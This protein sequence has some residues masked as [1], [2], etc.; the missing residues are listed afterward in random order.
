MANPVLIIVHG[1]GKHTKES[2]KK[3]F[4]DGSCWALNLYS[5]YAGKS[6]NDY[7]DIVPIS[8]NE[9]F[10]DHRDR[11]ANQASPLSERL[12][13]IAG[14]KGT[15][16]SKAIASLNNIDV[17]INNDEHF[18]THWLDVLLYRFTTLGEVA[19][20]R[21]GA[22]ISKAVGTVYGGAERVHVLGHSLGCAVVHDCLAKLYDKDYRLGDLDNLSTRMHKLGSVHLVANT[23][24]VLESFIKVNRSV[25]RPG[26]RGCTNYYREYRHSLDPITWAKPFNPTDNGNWISTSSMHY[27]LYKLLPTTSITN[28]HGNTHNIQH[29]LANPLVHQQLFERVFGI[30]FTAV[31]LEE[32]HQ[33]YI[34]NTLSGV[35]DNLQDSLEQLRELNLEN[36]QGLIKSAMVL[37]DFVERLG[38]QYE[39]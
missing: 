9:I 39:I 6:P 35:A 15:V 2:F 14:M 33:N 30:R 27:D 1:M 11:V 26:P 29:Y 8:Y 28:E 25:V 32:G 21:L 3:E 31:Q 20:I 24:R 19:R 16:L 5:D 12:Q 18:K 23:S 37:R 13:A 38:G 34:Q 10:D 4:I 36:V 17:E 7:V 22:E